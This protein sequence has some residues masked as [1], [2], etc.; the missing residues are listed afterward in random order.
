LRCWGSNCSGQHALA[1]PKEMMAQAD[2]HRVVEIST[3]AVHHR[4]MAATEDRIEQCVAHHL[5][6][7]RFDH[8]EGPKFHRALFIQPAW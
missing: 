5:G 7:E 8:P 6:W 1:L 4:C 2:S 3:I